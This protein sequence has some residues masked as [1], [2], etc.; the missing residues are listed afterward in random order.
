MSVQTQYALPLA[1]RPWRE[2]IVPQCVFC[3]IASGL[4]GAHL[5]HEDELTVAFLDTHPIRPGHVQVIP[6]DHHATFDDLPPA[7]AARIVHVGQRVAKALKQLHG[8]P[9]VAFLFTGGDVAHAHAHV[10]A[11][12]EKTDITSRRYIAEEHLTFRP[13]PQISAEELSGIAATLRRALG[14][15]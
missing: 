3:A 15:A 13:T 10:V 5:V 2:S 7:I 1:T 4:I 6:R 9:R 11:M 12:H 14:P 8:V